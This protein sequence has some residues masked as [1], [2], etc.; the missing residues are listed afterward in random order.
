M[1]GGAWEQ[2][3]AKRIEFQWAR[4]GGIG[5][6]E[7]GASKKKQVFAWDGVGRVDYPEAEKE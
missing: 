1:V 7:A 6:E 4:A 3:P 2:G 5:A